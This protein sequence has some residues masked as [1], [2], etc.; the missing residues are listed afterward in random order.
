ML[1]GPTM[2][3]HEEKLMDQIRR[4]E[5]CDDPEEIRIIRELVNT[6]LKQAGPLYYPQAI[7]TETTPE[8]RLEMLFLLSQGFRFMG[9]GR[10]KLL[11]A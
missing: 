6:S 1:G 2:F 8:G 5:L 4:I 10:P 7:V 11:T 3:F 9:G